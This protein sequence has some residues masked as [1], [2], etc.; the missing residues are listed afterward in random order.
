ML[1]LRVQEVDDKSVEVKQD[2]F[3]LRYWRRF[4]LGR[5]ATVSFGLD[6]TG[7]HDCYRPK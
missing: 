5:G 6:V 4:P 3:I 7:S 1:A 2:E